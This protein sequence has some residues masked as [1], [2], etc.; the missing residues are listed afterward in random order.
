MTLALFDGL[1]AQPAW[2]Q[3]WV[4]WLIVVNSAAIFFLRRKPARVVL[5]AWLVNALLMTVL[6][7]LNGY[8]RLL[9]LSHVVVWTPLLVYL[10]RRYRQGE[11]GVSSIFDRWLKVLFVTDLLSLFVDYA[12][13][14]RYL[15]GNP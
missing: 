3:I 10:Y 13:V 15:V 2:L 14:V 4:L 7:E 1:L 5:V 12:D 9:G 11:I 6:A 8:N